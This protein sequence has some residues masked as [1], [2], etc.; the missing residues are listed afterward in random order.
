VKLR[1]PDV[2]LVVVDTS[3][4]DL[5]KL[6]V[7]EALAQA[8]F[9][10]A[11]IFSDQDIPVHGARCFDC[12]ATNKWDAMKFRWYGI[13]SKIES[14]HVLIMEWDSGIINPAM[15]RDEF[16]GFDYIGAPWWHKDGLNV[17]NGGFSLRSK[18]LIEY[19]AESQSAFPFELEEDNTLCRK[20]RPM[21]QELG[22]FKW[23]PD[24]VAIDFAFE[25][26]K[27]MERERKGHF[28]FH[29]LRNWP[30][31]FTD[32]EIEFRLPMLPRAV[33]KSNQ[34]DHMRQVYQEINGSPFVSQFLDAMKR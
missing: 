27:P 9:H 12:R 23:A 30:W 14:S 28:G 16:L 2:T 3:C 21:I 34:I 11:L 15:W 5:T 26:V 25:C 18:R 13:A 1:L 24:D 10:D 31:V 20:H 8:E 29:A 6:A 4:H 22:G 32:E 19:V 33:L 7:N 17:G